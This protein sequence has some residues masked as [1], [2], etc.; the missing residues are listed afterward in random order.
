MTRPTVFVRLATTY[1]GP[2]KVF[3]SQ[4]IDIGNN[5][6]HLII[7]S[8]TSL[9]ALKFMNFCSPREDYRAISSITTFLWAVDVD[10]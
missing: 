5:V 10:H 6:L 4:G 2:G 3:P 8:K 1:A 9:K 7:L